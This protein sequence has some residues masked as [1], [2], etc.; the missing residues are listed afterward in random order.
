[1]V[2]E[3]EYREIAE[4]SETQALDGL[5]A[6]IAPSMIPSH[7]VESDEFNYQERTEIFFWF[8]KRLLIQGKLRLAKNGEFLTDSIDEQIL[9][10]YQAFPKIEDELDD[11]GWFFD[12]ACPGGAVWVLDDG[13]LEWT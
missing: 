12:D 11:G 5:W 7:H 8:L 3:S 1:M 4:C 13:S 10:F 2:T 6:Y 9:Q